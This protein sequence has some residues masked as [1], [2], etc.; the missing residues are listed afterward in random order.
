MTFISIEFLI[1]FAV[2]SVA[3]TVCD[4]SRKRQ[5]ILLIV[6]YIFYAYWDIRF[7]G[8]LL[9]Q[10]YISYQ[11]ACRIADIQTDKKKRFTAPAV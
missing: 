4:D 6:S 10:T 5:L 8:L 3:F 11:T 1:L 9:L 7:L 2:T